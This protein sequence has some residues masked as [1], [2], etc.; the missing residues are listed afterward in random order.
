MVFKKHGDIARAAR[1]LRNKEDMLNKH[2]PKTTHF[3]DT[4]SKLR[5]CYFL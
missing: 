3:Y 5:N 2:I 4:F 1:L